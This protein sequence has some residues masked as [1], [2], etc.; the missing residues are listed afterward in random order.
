MN[1]LEKHLI[2]LIEH[3]VEILD[4]VSKLNNKM[5]SD[6]KW[7]LHSLGMALDYHLGPEKERSP[8]DCV[9]VPDSEWHCTCK[10]TCGKCKKTFLKRTL[11]WDQ[12]YHNLCRDCH[13]KEEYTRHED[14]IN[15]PG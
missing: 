3:D 13:N 9:C 11:H 10:G 6:T 2:H 4:M 8:W 7:L 12:I 5:A 15:S 1:K 14:W